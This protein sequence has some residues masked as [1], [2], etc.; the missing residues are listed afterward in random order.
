MESSHSLLLFSDVFKTHAYKESSIGCYL[1]Q[2]LL[3]QCD[4]MLDRTNLRQERLIWVPGFG[5]ILDH[6]GERWWILWWCTHVAEPF[7]SSVTWNRR[8]TPNQVQDTALKGPLLV[9]YHLTS[10]SQRFSH[11]H[12]MAPSVIKQVFIHI[13]LEGTLHAQTMTM[14][15]LLVKF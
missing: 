3:S 1:H 8:L 10:M 12:K 14:F 2:S 11:P 15:S 5:G 7:A 9:T 13:S 6:S 4:Q